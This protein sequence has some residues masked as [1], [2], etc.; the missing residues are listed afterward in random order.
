MQLHL[1]EHGLGEYRFTNFMEAQV[2]SSCLP[3][4][5]FIKPRYPTKAVQR[6]L[7]DAVVQHIMVKDIV[8]ADG[9][10]PLEGEGLHTF[11]DQELTL[12]GRDALLLFP[13]APVQPFFEQIGSAANKQ[14]RQQV[15]RRI[16]GI[17]TDG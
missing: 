6:G 4:Y 8:T 9:F 13:V 16:A 12:D 7:Q 2:K 10:A 5:F 11:A 17:G 1:P 3:P 15:Q 14:V